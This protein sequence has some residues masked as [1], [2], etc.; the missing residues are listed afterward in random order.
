[1]TTEHLYQNGWRQTGGGR[2]AHPK[3]PHGTGGRAQLHTL[4]RAVEIQQAWDLLQSA[5]ET[6]GQS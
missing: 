1:M 3:T 6:V 2:W 5:C 4:E